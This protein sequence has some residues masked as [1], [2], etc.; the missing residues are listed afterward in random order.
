MVNNNVLDAMPIVA[1]RLQW[2]CCIEAGLRYVLDLK[3]KGNDLGE[4]WL[5][6]SSSFGGEGENAGAGHGVVP[7]L[8]FSSRLVA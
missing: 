1:K 4:T 8:V 5:R 6:C 2:E 7:R 3:E